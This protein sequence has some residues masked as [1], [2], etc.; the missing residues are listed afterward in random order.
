[1]YEHFLYY[2]LILYKIFNSVIN[3]L[4]LLNY[5]YTFYYIQ[6]VYFEAQNEQKIEKNNKIKCEYL[7]TAF[8]IMG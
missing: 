1:M 7:K 8:L 4:L 6:S 3:L 2:L 5:D